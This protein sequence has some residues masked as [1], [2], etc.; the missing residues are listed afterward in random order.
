[1]KE[2][3]DHLVAEVP[4]GQFRSEVTL[5]VNVGDFWPI[6]AELKKNEK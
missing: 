3:A 6:T 2:S 5:G 4:H 1:M